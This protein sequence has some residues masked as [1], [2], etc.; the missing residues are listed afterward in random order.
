MNVL[1]TG[2]FFDEGGDGVIHHVNLESGRVET[3]A[4]WHPPTHL[5]VAH[6]GLAGARRTA[7]HLYVAAHAAVVRWDLGRA[8]VDGVLHQPDFNDLHDVAVTDEELLV[9]NTGCDAIDRFTL[10]GVFLGRATWTPAWIN[11]RRL[12]GDEPAGLAELCSVGWSGDAP[13]W[14]ARTDEDGYHTPPE[15]RARMSFARSRVADRVH[16][17]H[18]T[19]VDGEWLAT[20]L[21]DGALRSLSSMT[22]RIAIPGHPHDGTLDGDEVWLTTI[23]GGIW[24][25]RR[26]LGASPPQRVAEAFSPGRVGWCRGL[27]LTADHVIVGLTEVRR[28]RLPRH[29]WADADPDESVT[30][31]VVLDRHGGEVLEYIDLTDR[32]RHHKIYSIVEIP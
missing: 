30:G 27:L 13:R 31:L 24:R 11:S 6:K 21:Y 25:V 7:D 18:V 12:Q 22:P 28:D 9:V 2:G 20:C 8:C 5:A 17:N 32:T 14:K 15:E 4:R 3:W 29:R 26:P 10:G 23:D 19:H 16:P 1:V